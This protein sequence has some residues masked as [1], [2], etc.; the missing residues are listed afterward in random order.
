[1][2]P[3]AT[4]YPVL[5]DEAIQEA[6]RL[7]GV[8]LRTHPRKT[9]AGKDALLMFARA[10]GSRNPLFQEETYADST[11]WGGL[12]AHPTLLYV[13]DDTVVACSISTAYPGVFGF[14]T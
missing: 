3:T 4:K 13:V 10:I 12:V 6:R 1:M 9:E 11:F 7:V 8:E 14:S 5:T 2:N